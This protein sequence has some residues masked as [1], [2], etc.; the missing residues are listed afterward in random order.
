MGGDFTQNVCTA[1]QAE[2]HNLAV[3]ATSG[4]FTLGYNGATTSDIMY[5]ASASTVKTEI[6]SLVVNGNALLSSHSSFRGYIWCWENLGIT[7]YGTN[8]DIGN[9]VVDKLTCQGGVVQVTEITGG[10]GTPEVQRVTTTDKSTQFSF[11]S[12]D[13]N[14]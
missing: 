6:E 8:G 10:C 2:V 4:T 1:G 12:E 5:N 3:T 11:L 9:L 14:K 7:F 13:Y